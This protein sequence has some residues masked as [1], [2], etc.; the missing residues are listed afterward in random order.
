MAE[1]ELDPWLEDSTAREL[2]E[3]ERGLRSGR[4]GYG[5]AY[6]LG[7]REE[8]DVEEEDDDVGDA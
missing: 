5:L 3:E 2:A 8:E 4:P 1:Y 7:P 6:G